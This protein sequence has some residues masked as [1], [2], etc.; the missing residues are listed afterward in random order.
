M[1]NN[2]LKIN[3]YPGNEWLAAK[4]SIAGATTTVPY[5]HGCIRGHLAHPLPVDAMEV[6]PEALAGVK[7][8][9]MAPEDRTELELGLL[10]L[11]SETARSFTAIGPFPVAVNPPGRTQP[12]ESRFLRETSELAVGF[13]KG[14]KAR[15]PPVGVRFSC[16]GSWIKDLQNEGDWCRMMSDHPDKLRSELPEDNHRRQVLF[17]AMGW[18]QECM[19]WVELY[20]RMDMDGAATMVHS[21]DLGRKSNCVC[22]SGKKYKHCCQG[23]ESGEKTVHIVGKLIS[24]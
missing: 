13:V 19:G 18:I 17:D 23:K 4:L 12:D 20:A 16:A 11:W 1:S 15:R 5:I 6:L 7:L 22:G 3:R 21:G 2:T 9:A 8:E 24:R 14:F 10:Q